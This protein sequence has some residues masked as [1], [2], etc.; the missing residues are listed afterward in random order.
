M[1]FMGFVVVIKISDVYRDKWRLCVLFSAFD[2]F[3]VFM[4]SIEIIKKYFIFFLF[5]YNI[6]SNDNFDGKW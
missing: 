2:L 4:F 3:F 6:D 5:Y 1:Y